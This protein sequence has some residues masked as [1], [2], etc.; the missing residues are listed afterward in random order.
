MYSFHYTT[1]LKLEEVILFQ[2]LR[3]SSFNVS[4]V[5]LKKMYSADGYIVKSLNANCKLEH[6]V[7]VLKIHWN[8]LLENNIMAKLRSSR[9]S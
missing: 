1:N 9:L 8:G 5:N 4:Y 3:R 2:L 7:Y 6:N